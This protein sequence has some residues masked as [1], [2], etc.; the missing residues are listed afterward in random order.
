MELPGKSGREK[1]TLSCKGHVH[2]ITAE[3]DPCLMLAVTEDRE[4]PAR[5]E[6]APVPSDLP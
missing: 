1:E 5:V 6:S 4:A 3:E 2:C